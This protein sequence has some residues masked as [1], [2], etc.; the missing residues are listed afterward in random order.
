MSI[1]TPAEAVIGGAVLYVASDPR[2]KAMA[3]E[4]D[5]EHFIEGCRQPW[6]EQLV[7][8][9]LLAVREVAA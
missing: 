2:I 3:D 9:A 8:Q 6:F 5:E 7:G 1:L 4:N